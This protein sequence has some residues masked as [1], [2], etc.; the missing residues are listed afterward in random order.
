[1]R[2]TPP[3]PDRRADPRPPATASSP[4]LAAAILG[5]VFLALGASGA[6]AYWFWPPDT[7]ARISYAAEP[8]RVWSGTD[9]RTVAGFARAE[10]V[11]PPPILRGEPR[12]FDA[13]RLAV[14]DPAPDAPRPVPAEEAAQAAEQQAQS[15]AVIRDRPRA[16]PPQRPLRTVAPD[17]PPSDRLTADA[18]LDR[19][20]RPAPR[21]AA[22]AAIVPEAQPIPARLAAAPAVGDTCEAAALPSRP[23]GAPGGRAALARL[24]DL[25]G[26][27][28]D[29]A[30]ARAVLSG[31]FP[32]FQRRLVPVTLSGRTSA[33]A[34]ARITICVLPDYLALGH[35]RDFVRVPMGLPAASRIA[36]RFGMLL[37][38]ARMVDAIHAQA[39]LRLAPQPMT[40]GPQMESTDYLLRH[41][42]TLEAQRNRAGAAAGTLIAGHK[43]DLV[44][45]NR[46][47]TRPGRV[48]IYGWH[49]RDGRPIQPLSTVHG[50]GYADYSHGVRLIG[51][52]AFVDGRATDLRALLAD[53]RY[54]GILSDEGPLGSSVLL[55]ALQ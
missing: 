54:A 4:R 2:K 36:E 49:H 21:P 18:A 28:R 29:A 40:P 16:R 48:A 19:S 22:S 13:P 5:L 15:V 30:V 45:T 8:P 1:M 35:D 39:P 50:A 41:N 14:S 55:A 46:L 9:A 32:D 44:L 47:A 12:G 11:E 3:S 25:S 52:T 7:P 43:K 53:P 51:G 20:P 27:R 17:A 42:A 37:P 10:H 26:S 24:A 6:A 23:A 38:T 34:R 31:N 33:G